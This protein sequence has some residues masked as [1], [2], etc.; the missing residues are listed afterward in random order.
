M[1]FPF[2]KAVFLAGTPAIGWVAFI[3]ELKLT[4]DPL[5]KE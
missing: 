1:S 4:F 5:G 3:G 2:T